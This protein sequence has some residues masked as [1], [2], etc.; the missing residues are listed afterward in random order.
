MLKR[1][2]CNKDE[3]VVVRD[4]QETLW[5][6]ARENMIYS[7]DLTESLRIDPSGPRRVQSTVP[8]RVQST[9]AHKLPYQKQSVPNSL[10]DMTLY[11]CKENLNP[12]AQ[13]ANTKELNVQIRVLQRALAEQDSDL[14]DACKNINK[15]AKECKALGKVCTQLCQLH[16]N[17]LG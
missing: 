14:E 5:M 10:R 1:H 16:V 11:S 4:S 8:R 9:V 6:L 3:R 7:S 12:V 17:N 13:D 15:K 2:C